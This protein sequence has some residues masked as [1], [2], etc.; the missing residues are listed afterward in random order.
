[1]KPVKLIVPKPQRSKALNALLATSKKETR[2][3]GDVQRHLLDPSRRDERPNDVLHPSELSHDE[4]CHR[5][6]YYQLMGLLPL[7]DPPVPSWRR[8][9][10]FDEGHEI[11][12][13]WQNWFW[14]IA[15]LAGI[16]YCLNCRTAWWDTAP[17]KCPSCEAGRKLLRY[18]EVPLHHDRLRIG[19][20]ADGRDTDGSNIEIKSIGIGTLRIE[21]PELLKTHT[22]KFRVNGAEREFIDLDGLW[23]GIRRPLPTHMRQGHLYSYLAIK[24]QRPTNGDEIYIYEAKWHQG[25]KEFVV[26]YNQ[27][28][29]QGILDRV[30]EICHC[31]QAQKPPKCI[32]GGCLMCESYEG[33]NGKPIE[34]PP[35][36]VIRR[37]HENPGIP[38]KTRRISRPS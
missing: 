15:R 34:S 8:Q 21:Q 19:G 25:V 1:M 11:H 27:D 28:R 22:Y 32:F 4:W 31:L 37:V 5:A 6:G 24:S 9:M 23:N 2:I 26:K 7:R 35:K 13:K 30:E 16:F 14:D 38:E 3:L 36:R 17:M 12:R 18:D 29:I 33:N 10:L 20:H